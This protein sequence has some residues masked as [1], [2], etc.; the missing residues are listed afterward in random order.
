VSRL[1]NI[2]NCIFVWLRI[3][4]LFFIQSICSVYSYYSLLVLSEPFSSSF[5]SR[6][7][8]ASVFRSRFVFDHE[9]VN[10]LTDTDK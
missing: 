8:I 9:N 3:F 7:R 5:C 4:L 6:E 10:H 1:D 2:Q